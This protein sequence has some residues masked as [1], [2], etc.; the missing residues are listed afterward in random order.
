MFKGKTLFWK[1]RQNIIHAKNTTTND[2]RVRGYCGDCLGI[3]WGYVGDMLGIC[4]GYFGDVL[5]LC[6]GFVGVVLGFCWGLLVVFVIF[7]FAMFS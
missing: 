1:T 4:W 5:G 7:D 6:W 2:A 3:V